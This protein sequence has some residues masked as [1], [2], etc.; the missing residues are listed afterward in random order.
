M[1]GNYGDVLRERDIVEPFEMD[2][3][4]TRYLSGNSDINVTTRLKQ[5][6]A[7]LGTFVCSSVRM[8]FFQIAGHGGIKLLLC[9]Y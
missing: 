4:V 8:F 9:I 3:K 2:L 5:I 1:L 6:H 7:N